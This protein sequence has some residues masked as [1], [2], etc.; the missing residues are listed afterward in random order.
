MFGRGDGIRQSAVRRQHDRADAV[1]QCEIDAVVNRVVEGQRQ[2]NR[3]RADGLVI[4]PAHRHIGKQGHGGP[5]FGALDLAR[6]R[7]AP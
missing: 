7:L 4:V 1:R 3:I 5:G 6:P 2:A